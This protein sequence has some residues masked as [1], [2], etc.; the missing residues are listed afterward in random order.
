ED[1]VMIVHGRLANRSA[2]H[3]YGIHF[4]HGAPLARLE[5]RIALTAPAPRMPDLRRAAA[6]RLEPL[7]GTAVYGAKRVPV[8]FRI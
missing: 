7:A 3:G 2:G 5:A 6:E 4:C 8:T 1:Q